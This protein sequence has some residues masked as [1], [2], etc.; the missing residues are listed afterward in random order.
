M[1]DHPQHRAPVVIG[2]KRLQN[3]NGDLVFGYDCSRAVT[4]NCISWKSG[5]EWVKWMPSPACSGNAMVPCSKPSALPVGEIGYA[6]KSIRGV[7]G[8]TQPLHVLK[9]DL[10]QGRIF[11]ANVESLGVVSYGGQWFCCQ[12]NRRL[13][14]FKQALDPEELVPVRVCDYEEQNADCMRPFVELRQRSFVGFDT[15]FTDSIVLQAQMGNLG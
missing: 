14:V 7:F 6:H 9:D 2:P 12:G 15:A 1:V 13:W 5:L 3:D 10:K 4:S 8:D 11:A